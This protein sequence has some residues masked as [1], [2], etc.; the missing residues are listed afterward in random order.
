MVAR[1]EATEVKVA[2]DRQRLIQVGFGERENCHCCTN[3]TGSG[4]TH[5][6]I[7]SPIPKR[8]DFIGRT[9]EQLLLKL[10]GPPHRRELF[11]P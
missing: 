11:S 2:G 9:H 10:F 7:E 6:G 5:R 4:L 8:F 3:L 1:V